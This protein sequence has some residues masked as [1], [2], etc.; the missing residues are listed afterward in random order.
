[1]ARTKSKKK[2]AAKTARK[3][4]KAARKPAKRAAGKRTP[5]AKKRG[6]SRSAAP[7]RKPAD[8]NAAMRALAQHIIDVS[9][10]HD[11]EAILGLYAPDIESSEAG[12][13]PVVGLGALREKFAGWRSMT[14]DN[15]FEPR[16]VLVDGNVIVVEWV[17]RVTLAATSKQIELHEV[18]VHEIKNGK[19]AR[20]AFFYNP[21]VFAG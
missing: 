9:L 13:P 1:M 6:A 18:A 4:V 17:G 16:R 10:G 19:I 2:T 3:T 8:P 15:V 21:A 5:V 12:Q 14:T 20:E 7:A 11:D